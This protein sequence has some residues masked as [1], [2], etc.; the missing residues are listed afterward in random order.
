MTGW[1]ERSSLWIP[2]KLHHQRPRIRSKLLRVRWQRVDSD[3]Y[4]LRTTLPSPH[5]LG[6]GLPNREAAGEVGEVS[7]HTLLQ[8][9]PRVL[10]QDVME[11]VAKYLGVHQTLD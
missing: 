3:R 4:L 2:L 11:S 1:D 9:K 6:L 7:V 5:F 8:L 10:K